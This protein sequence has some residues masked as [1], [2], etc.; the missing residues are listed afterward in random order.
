MAKFWLLNFDCSSALFHALWRAK[1]QYL[2]L[3]L[4]RMHTLDL[5]LFLLVRW[6]FFF[7]PLTLRALTKKFSAVFNLWHGENFSIEIY[8]TTFPVPNCDFRYE[9]LSFHWYFHIVLIGRSKHFQKKIRCS[10]VKNNIHVYA[11]ILGTARTTYF[12]T[13][14]LTQEKV[15]KSHPYCISYLRMDIE[16]SSLSYQKSRQNFCILHLKCQAKMKITIIYYQ[17]NTDVCAHV[18]TRV[19]WS[20]TS[21]KIKFE[22]RN[23]LNCTT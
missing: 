11:Y 3:I 19:S 5:S 16:H 4:Q 21:G 17:L 7:V 9:Y 12:E 20:C 14:N 22:S 13:T 8:I 2:I 6:Y 15:I 1:G 10:F 18:V 23:V